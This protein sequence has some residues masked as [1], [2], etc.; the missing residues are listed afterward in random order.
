MNNKK[1]NELTLAAMFAALT[2]VATMIIKI[3]TPGTSGYVHLGD[4]FVILC[5]I[6]LGPAHG[7][8]AAGMGSALSDL[9][10]GYF[11]YVPITFLVKGVVAV[12]VHFV[13][14]KLTNTIK[15]PVAK[16]II[17]GFF[18]TILVALG[19]FTFEIFLYGPAAITS[20]PANLVQGLSGLVISSI[21]LPILLK[22]HLRTAQVRA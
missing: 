16:C 5:G 2:C 7:F 19:Y 21:L 11:Q 3:P 17:S 4:T 14:H 10:G 18:S 22:V 1:L 20:I 9:L 8:L 13:Y 6:F 12:V 15:V